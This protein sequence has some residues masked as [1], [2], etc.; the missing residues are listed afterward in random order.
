VPQFVAS[1]FYAGLGNQFPKRNGRNFLLL[2]SGYYFTSIPVT[3]F[4][5]RQPDA[6]IGMNWKLTL[7]WRLSQLARAGL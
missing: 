6:G 1:L 4:A 2:V 3:A 5:W 7:E